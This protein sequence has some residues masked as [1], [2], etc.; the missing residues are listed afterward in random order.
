MSSVNLKN[1]AWFRVLFLG[2][3]SESY[4]SAELPPNSKAIM[5]SQSFTTDQPLTV[6]FKYFDSG[7]TAYKVCI[8][9]DGNC[10]FTAAASGA[11]TGQW[12]DGSLTIPPGT[13]TVTK[14]SFC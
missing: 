1:H 8:D 3:S 4:A 7:N 14:T 5:Q 13:H 2:G 9:G 10:P 12:K 11:S 6:T